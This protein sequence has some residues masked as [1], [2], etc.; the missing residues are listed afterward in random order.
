VSQLLKIFSW[1]TWEEGLAIFSQS[2]LIKERA[3][4]EFITKIL[5]DEDMANALFM[6]IKKLWIS[7][8]VQ[9]KA[10]HHYQ[11]EELVWHIILFNCAFLFAE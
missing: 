9:G 5:N 6:N 7:K 11:K 1:S 3:F 2:F 8:R 4:I 10:M